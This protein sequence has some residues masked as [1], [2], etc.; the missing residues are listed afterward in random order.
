MQVSKK[1][2]RDVLEEG[3]SYQGYMLKKEN[4]FK[5]KLLNGILRS[6]AWYRYYCIIYDNHLYCFKNQYA[7]DHLIDIALKGSY[8]SASV[9]QEKNAEFVFALKSRL[10]ILPDHVF[11]T[12]TKYEFKKWLASI[13]N[14]INK[15]EEKKP[16]PKI[17]KEAPKITEDK[18]QYVPI[19]SDSDE[20][21]SDS[22][23]QTEKPQ[24]K[25]LTR[26]GTRKLP[27]LPLGKYR[28]EVLK[29][30][31]A[32]VKQLGEELKNKT[33]FKQV[34]KD[35]KQQ[36]SSAAKFFWDSIW[37]DTDEDTNELLTSLNQ[38]GVYLVRRSSTDKSKYV[39]VVFYIQSNNPVIMKYSITETTEDG[40]KLYF[41]ESKQQFLS[42]EEL[43]E[44]YHKNV[45]PGDTTQMNLQ[46][47]I[48]LK[49]KMQKAN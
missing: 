27:A 39:L 16:E 26:C 32:L 4:K 12:E 7:K 9:H 13:N 47:E 2:T 29:Q 46:L 15:L 25:P 20:S 33:Q 6:K 36:L 23:S 10:T 44:H 35:A 5:N 1:I 38:S 28:I 42:I 48:P 14:E 19:M 40:E 21:D 17:C 22:E 24:M 45:L 30:N 34:N 49:V 11:L 37:W 8:S 31:Q 3:A 18:E 43:C 41:L